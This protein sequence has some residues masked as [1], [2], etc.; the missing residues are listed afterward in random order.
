M[1]FHGAGRCK[2]P[3][4]RKAGMSK[5]RPPAGYPNLRRERPR[6]AS[7]TEAILLLFLLLGNQGLELVG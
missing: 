2:P 1:R 7:V 6:Q 3:A 4:L 5:G